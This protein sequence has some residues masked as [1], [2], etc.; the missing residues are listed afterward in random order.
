MSRLLGPFQ[1]DQRARLLR[2]NLGERPRKQVGKVRLDLGRHQGPLNGRSS[3][4]SD[5]QAVP[6]GRVLYLPS[7]A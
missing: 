4:E 3:Y 5:I 6:E 7:R 1:G 2:R